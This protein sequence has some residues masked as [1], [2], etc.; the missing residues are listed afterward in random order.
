[1]V[2]ALEKINA[3]NYYIKFV[4]ISPSYY[5]GYGLAEIYIDPA[6]EDYLIIATKTDNVTADSPL[7]EIIWPLKLRI[8]DPIQ[9]KIWKPI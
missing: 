9:V 1:M 4:G 7:S 8:V 2:T 6:T 3:T 5:V